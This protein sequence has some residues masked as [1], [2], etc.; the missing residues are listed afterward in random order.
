MKSCAYYDETV[1]GCCTHPSENRSCCKRGL[2]TCLY[3]N[4]HDG[5]CQQPLG[6]KCDHTCHMP[7]ETEN[8]PA[9]K[10]ICYQ[11]QARVFYLFDDGRCM[12]CTRMTVEEVRGDSTET[13]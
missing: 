4:K 11:C 2:R 12:K 6:E 13:D 1:V 5:K 9:A 8:C 7:N 10:F 3:L